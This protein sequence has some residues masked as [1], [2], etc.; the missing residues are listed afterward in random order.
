MTRPTTRYVALLE[1]EGPGTS[2]PLLITGDKEV[3]ESVTRILESR[4][5]CRIEPRIPQSEPKVAREGT[6]GDA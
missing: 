5:M 1:G 4:L 3:V 6:H 2:R